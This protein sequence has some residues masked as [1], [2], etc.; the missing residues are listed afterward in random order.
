[1]ADFKYGGESMR[2]APLSEAVRSMNRVQE[3]QDTDADQRRQSQQDS[4]RKR[5]EEQTEAV[6]DEKVQAAISAFAADKQNQ[7]VGITA[8]KDGTGPGLRVY[9]RD[10][11]GTVIRQMTGEEFLKVREAAQDG[12]VRGKILDQKL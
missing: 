3:K 11:T 5:D 10:G 9:L 6:T 1:L 8:H 12:R 7:V 4:R 2:V